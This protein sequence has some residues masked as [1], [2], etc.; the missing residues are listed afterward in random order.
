MRNFSPHLQSRV[1]RSGPLPLEAAIC[2]YVHLHTP[3][4]PQTARPVLNENEEKCMLV[5]VLPLF[6]GHLPPKHPQK[7]AKNAKRHMKT[8]YTSHG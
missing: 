7:Q 2:Y 3:G 8:R 5:P 1:C 4:G 6:A